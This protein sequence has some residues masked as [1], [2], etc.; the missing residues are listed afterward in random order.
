MYIYI[1]SLF[2]TSYV[3]GAGR[4]PAIARALVEPNEG[5]GR[6]GGVKIGG[7]NLSHN[8]YDTHVFTYALSI[9]LCN[10]WDELRPTR[11]Y[12]CMYDG[13]TVAV[14]WP[15]GGRTVAARWPHGG[16]RFLI[17]SCATLRKLS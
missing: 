10:V 1:Y 4:W 16:H 13:R 15:Y 8:G 3:G 2:L 14:R 6:V 12:V 9:Y 11:G 5:S 7:T 17:Q